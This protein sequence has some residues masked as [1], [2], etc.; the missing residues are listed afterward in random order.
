MSTSGTRSTQ[1][2]GGAP[3]D[4]AA[5]AAGIGLWVIVGAGLAYGVTQ[6]AVKVAAL[7]G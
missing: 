7:F 3:A 1:R 5:K 2:T 6:T 4:G